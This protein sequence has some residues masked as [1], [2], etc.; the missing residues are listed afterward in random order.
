MAGRLICIEKCSGVRPVGIDDTCRWLFLDM[1]EK[2]VKERI[3]KLFLSGRRSGDI[4]GEEMFVTRLCHG[5]IKNRVVWKRF[6]GWLSL[7]DVKKHIKENNK[8]DGCETK[9]CPVHDGQYRP[10]D[11]KEARKVRETCTS[12]TDSKKFDGLVGKDNGQPPVMMKDWIDIIRDHMI[13][14]GMWDVLQ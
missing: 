2:V 5:C 7:K 6:M 12:Y 4:R 8:K 10:T 1:L 9:V 13:Q 11:H 14:N 3:S